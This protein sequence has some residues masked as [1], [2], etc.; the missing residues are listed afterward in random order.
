MYSSTPKTQ[1]VFGDKEKISVLNVSNKE[2]P[3]LPKPCIDLIRT[4]HQSVASNPQRRRNLLMTVSGWATYCSLSS[5]ALRYDRPLDSKSRRFTILQASDMA[6]MAEV[7]AE[8]SAGVSAG[9]SAGTSTEGCADDSAVGAAAGSDDASTDDGNGDGIP[10][11]TSLQL[12]LSQQGLFAV[13]GF[14]TLS[15]NNLTIAAPRRD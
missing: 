10:S 5:A 4:P 6:Y 3:R 7:S 15:A 9:V 13:L 2:A 12:G 11:C 14:L 1:D 8:A